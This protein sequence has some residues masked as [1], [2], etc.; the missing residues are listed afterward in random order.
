MSERLNRIDKIRKEMK[1]RDIDFYIVCTDDFHGSEYVGDYF[2][3]R[4]YLSGFTGSSGTLVIGRQ[5]A[6]L[7]TDGRYFLQAQEQLKGTTIQ[8]MKMGM[9]GV[10]TIPEYLEKNVPYGGCVGYDGRCVT[11]SFAKQIQNRLKD[12]EVKFQS[13]GDLVE[14]IWTNRPKLS[15]QPVW[16]LDCSITGHRRDK[17]LQKLRDEMN[18]IGAQY[19]ILTSLDDIAWLLGLR[20][21]DIPCNPVFLSYLLIDAKKAALYINPEIVSK[22]IVDKLAKDNIAIKRYDS[23]YQDLK[24]L[25]VSGTILI[26]ETHANERIRQSIPKDMKRINQI[27]PV[28][29][30]KAIK[31]KEECEHMRIAH[32]KDGVA[33]TKFMYWLKKNV[34]KQ[35][36]TEISSAKKL[37]E[38]RKAGE[39]YLQPSFDPIIAYAEHGAIVHYSATKESDKELKPKGLCLAD[40]GGQYLDGTTDI[41]RTFALGELTKEEKRAYTLVLMG[42]INLASANFMYGV[43]GVNLDYIARKPLWEHGLDYNHGTGHGVGFLLNVHEAPNAFRYKLL[44]QMQYNAIMEEG[45]ITSNEPGVYI[46]DKFGVRLENLILCKKAKKTEFGQFMEF[47]TLTLVPFDLDAIESNLLSEEQKLWLNTYHER[48]RNALSKYL[49]PDEKIWLEKATRAI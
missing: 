29:L 30:M 23:I 12:K 43:R 48:V 36:I 17:D 16:E 6:L 15:A 18:K 13:E 38:F 20:G 31:T 46:K 37:E 41:T 32:L 9:E 21:N 22:T 27:S 33:V 14:Q 26:D 42:H 25:S 47:E 2:K 34:G 28:T 40:T 8:L 7:W 3:V 5:E 35:K 49:K 10:D 19:F 39:G 11:I 45:M 24:E 1:K 44:P 4:E